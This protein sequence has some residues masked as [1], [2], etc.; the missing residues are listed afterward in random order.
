MKQGYVFLFLALFA[1]GL[2]YA[3]CIEEIGS[4]FGGADENG[5]LPEGCIQDLCFKDIK[6]FC[7]QNKGFPEG[8]YEE[9]MMPCLIDNAW[10]NYEAFKKSFSAK[11]FDENI[12][13]C[14]KQR[15]AEAAEEARQKKAGNQNS[16]EMENFLSNFEA[17]M[18]S[19]K[20]KEKAKSAKLE[21]IITPDMEKIIS[22]LNSI[23]SLS[24]EK[25]KAQNDKEMM[26]AKKDKQLAFIDSERES[27]VEEM[28]QVVKKIEASGVSVALEDVSVYDFKKSTYSVCEKMKLGGKCE[29]KYYTAMYIAPNA[30]SMRPLGSDFHYLGSYAK[31]GFSAR[32][33]STE[34]FV[35]EAERGKYNITGKITNMRILEAQQPKLGLGGITSRFSFELV[36]QM[37]SAKYV[38]KLD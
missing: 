4:L 36:V 11:C 27:L 32:I 21:K 8:C 34:K 9:A 1:T 29:E 18:N 12:K 19:A 30:E 22:I 16:K 13:K 26:K 38:G 37:E 2:S 6:S 35:E 3:G 7:A 24:R 17:V 15:K 25:N 20:E 23:D 5:K 14:Q 33:I 28:N 10:R 31:Y